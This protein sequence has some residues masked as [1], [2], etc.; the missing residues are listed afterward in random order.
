MDTTETQLCYNKTNG[1]NRVTVMLQS[2]QWIQQ[3]HS[4][5]TVRPP[6]TTELQLCCSKTNGY[7][8]V[9]VILQ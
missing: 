6:D 5:S 3:S 4:C 8:R 2:D 7:K 9:T 1:Y